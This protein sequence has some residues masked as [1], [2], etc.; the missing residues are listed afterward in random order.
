MR[1]LV[2][3]Q[4]RRQ[5]RAAAGGRVAAD[6]RVDHA[7]AAI[8]SLRQPLLEQ[9]DPA[10]AAR[11]AVLGR[12]AVADDQDRCRRWPRR[13]CAATAQRRAKPRAPRYSAPA[14]LR[15]VARRASSNSFM[16]EPIIAVERVTKQVQ[17]LHRHAD[18]SPRHRFHAARAA[19]RRPSSARRA[20]ARARCCRSSPGSTRRPPARSGSPA[21]TCS[22]STR[23]RAPRCARA[24]VGFVFQS[25]QL[26]GNLNALENV[27]L[28]LELQGR[29]DARA[30]AT[31]M[32][33][34]RRPGRAAA[35]L[36]AGAVGRRAA[37]RRAGARL[38]R[39]AGGA[40]GRRA[41]RQ[42]RLRHRRDA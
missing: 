1:R 36:P 31:E 9:R 12:Q 13:R 34:P 26:L 11:Q 17:R 22:R 21:S 4:Q 6:A 19:S 24:K 25:F 37:A 5:A 28:P 16:S 38:R 35:P 18:D 40:A 3:R 33:Q 32:L 2:L 10:A 8:F 14:T 7:C 30:A 39:A 42:P 41:H 29:N 15:R 23:T 20:R 27:M